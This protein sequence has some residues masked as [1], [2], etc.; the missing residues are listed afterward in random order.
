MVGIAT[1]SLIP[2]RELDATLLKVAVCAFCAIEEQCL[3]LEH[4]ALRSGALLAGDFDTLSPEAG[5]GPRLRV[6]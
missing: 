1:A 6:E 2:S 5:V 4:F 3:L